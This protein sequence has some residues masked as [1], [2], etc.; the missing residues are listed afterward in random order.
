MK[1]HHCS[2]TFAATFGSVLLSLSVLFPALAAASPADKSRPNIIYILAD[3]LG[4]GDLGSY[5]QK[6]VKTPH[7]DRLASEGMRFTQH[8]SGS[9]VCGPSRSSLLEGLHTGRT[10]VRGN[11]NGQQLDSTRTTLPEALKAAGYTT[12]IIG[13]WGVGEPL[14][15]D[16]PQRHG[17]DHA[18]GYVNMFHAHNFF[19]EFLYRNGTKEP[20]PANL[21]DRSL[22]FNHMPEGTG[23]AKVKGT[24]APHL[25]EQ[26]A[27]NFIVTH[28][29]QPF[30][31]YLAL[32]L[33]HNNGEKARAT[34]DGSEVFDLGEFA[35]RDWP[36][37]ERG[38]AR[39]VQYVDLT[40][41]QIM[42][43][44]RELGLDENTLVIFD[45]DNGAYGGG[46]NVEF[47]DSNGPFRGFKRDLY[48]GGIRAPMIARWP[49]RIQP[50]TVSD[51]INAAWDLFPTFAEIAGAPVPADLDGISFLPTLLGKPGQKKHDHL[52]WEFY[53][54]VGSQAV[55]A[56]DW[57]A[58][59]L[60]LAN[61]K[62]E[63]LELYDLATDP[64]ET[65][66]LAATQPE[67]ANRL[68][69]LMSTSHR[70][71][72]VSRFTKSP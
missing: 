21:L 54:G 23:V 6:T 33:P 13:K 24:Y 60:N 65:R 36:P 1:H 61:D 3:D 70:P 4:L 43:R 14:P 22:P 51:H 42:A 44:L 48:E 10:S 35:D 15:V 58:V 56:G 71:H 63:K 52:Y 5:G 32:N 19:P 41:G 29:D 68:R 34:G 16:D 57:K 20:L 64:S 39:M 67:I 18:Y 8:Y 7:L 47:F 50:G 17:F 31:L 2:R 9:T 66:D 72:S 46:H 37:V 53:E 40:V 59:R 25:I 27:M 69:A 45:S 38:F 11:G 28:R 12:A 26:D 62:P 30:F 55:R 49:G